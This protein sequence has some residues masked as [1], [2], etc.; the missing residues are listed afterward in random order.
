[1]RYKLGYAISL[2]IIPSTMVWVSFQHRTWCIGIGFGNTL[3]AHCG[4]DRRVRNRL[5]LVS[6]T[7]SDFPSLAEQPTWAHGSVRPAA[8]LCSGGE[9]VLPV[10][11]NGELRPRAL[12]GWFSVQKLSRSAARMKRLIDHTARSW[13]L[14]AVLSDNQ[15]LLRRS[16]ARQIRRA[17]GAHQRNVLV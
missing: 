17:V 6:A 4:N 15:F 2:L 9:I 8:T 10:G 3:V 12:V 1:M 14:L 11:D 7:S 13:P 16:R 5:A